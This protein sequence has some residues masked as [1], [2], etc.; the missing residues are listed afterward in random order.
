M[1]RDLLT[2]AAYNGVCLA[3]EN[4][5]SEAF[6]VEDVDAPGGDGSFEIRTA[7]GAF[8]VSVTEVQS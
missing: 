7:E 1:L 6:G 2:A 5:E 4:G 8:K 3:V